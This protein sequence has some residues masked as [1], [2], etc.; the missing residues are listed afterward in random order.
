VKPSLAKVQD[1]KITL[2]DLRTCFKAVISSYKCRCGDCSAE[3][4]EY[5][6]IDHL[7]WD[8]SNT[9]LSCEVLGLWNTVGR[10]I[11]K[12]IS[13]CFVTPG[14]NVCFEFEDFNPL[15]SG[16]FD[17][18]L[19][20]LFNIFFQQDYSDAHGA[21][22]PLSWRSSPIKN[23]DLHRQILGIITNKL[24]GR[25]V[26]GCIGISSGASAIFPATIQNPAFEPLEYVLVEGEFRDAQNRYDVLISN[27]PLLLRTTS[28]PL[29]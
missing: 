7:F 20:F 3:P 9:Q 8:P 5:Q 16:E 25:W 28:K 24:E 26:P 11:L 29:C 15:I 19:Q 21:I 22:P 14:E 27:A 13:A 6:V 18:S 17:R 12:G 2:D 23:S 1:H 10:I 4:T